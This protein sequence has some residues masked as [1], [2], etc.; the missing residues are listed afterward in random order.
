MSKMS[1]KNAFTMPDIEILKSS[2][3]LNHPKEISWVALGQDLKIGL[4]TQME[5][6]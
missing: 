2:Y 1:T 3:K 4:K 6:S 5:T